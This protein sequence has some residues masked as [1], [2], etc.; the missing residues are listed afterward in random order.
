MRGNRGLGALEHAC[1]RDAGEDPLC[2][3]QIGRKDGARCGGIEAIRRTQLGVPE[4][5]VIKV[6]RPGSLD[7]AG[8]VVLALYGRY[9]TMVAEC[10][11]LGV[12][13]DRLWR[14]AACE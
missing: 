4:L 10:Q 3:L 1:L 7:H 14:S 12:V 5:R 9:I 8:K 11:N 13:R 2:S 6:G